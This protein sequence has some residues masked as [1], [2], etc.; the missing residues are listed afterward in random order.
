MPR[1]LKDFLILVGF[2]DPDTLTL[3]AR[4][5]HQLM[6]GPISVLPP[7][8]RHVDYEVIPIFIADGCLHKCGFCRV[9]SLQ[10]FS[11]RTEANITDQINQL[12]EF[13]GPDISNYNSIF[14]GQHDALYA[15]PELITF[16]AITAYKT[17]GFESSNIKGANL[18]LFGSVDAL[19]NS[20]KALFDM[21]AQLP[22]STYINIGLESV[23]P[24]TLTKIKKPI[25]PQ[26]VSDA[27]AKMLDINNQYEQIEISV[28]F[29]FGDEL[30]PNHLSAF[31]D[32]AEKTPPRPHGKG[33]LY[34][35]PL[36]DS[37]TEKN[38]GMIRKF[39]K[40]KALSPVAAVLYLIQRL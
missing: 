38:R 25:T 3:K 21:L 9:K 36:A 30:P 8:T 17:F 1:D 20:K 6:G 15:D 26:A 10:D 32:L 18:F 40:I 39:Y 5:F 28:N 33:T 16:A 13:Y 37:G 7:D 31:A 34:F 14:L 12:K 4:I 22:F 24:E 35:S 29:L 19:L 27:F 23:D 2:N 11:P